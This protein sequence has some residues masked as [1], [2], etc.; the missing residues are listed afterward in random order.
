MKGQLDVST[1]EEYFAAL[2][3]PRRTEIQRL[4]KLIRDVAPEFVPFIQSG[5]LSY[6]TFR[7]KYANG[8]QGDWMRIGIA[9]NAQYIS[10][11]CCPMDERGYIPERYKDRLPKANIGKSCVRFKR[12]EDLDEP[13]LRELIAEAAARQHAL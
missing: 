8:R 9:S 2:D 5:M 11:Y 1:P 13:A 10:L 12:V 3:E 4:D 7:F 6:G